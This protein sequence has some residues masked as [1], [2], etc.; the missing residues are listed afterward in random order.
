MFYKLYLL[1]LEV[2]WGEKKY[3]PTRD[4]NGVTSSRGSCTNLYTMRAGD[5]MDFT[6]II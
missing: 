1:V 5:K 4:R 3:A 2:K 6:H